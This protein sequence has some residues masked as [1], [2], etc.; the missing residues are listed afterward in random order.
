[1]KIKKGDNIKVIAGKDKGKTGIVLQVFPAMDRVSVEGVNLAV[2]HLKAQGKQ[3]GQKVQFPAALH[4]SNV[5]LIDPKT[6]KPTRVGYKRLATNGGT[7][8]ARIS[9]KTGEVIA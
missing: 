9:K 7:K 6:N 5:M 1:M 3:P 2:K 4:V 8:K